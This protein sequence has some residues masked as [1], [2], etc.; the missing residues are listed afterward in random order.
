MELEGFQGCPYGPDSEWNITWANTAPGMN[1]TQPCPGGVNTVG[2]IV[3]VTLRCKCFIVFTSTSMCFT[4]CTEKEE[5]TS[6]QFS[7]RQFQQFEPTT[8]LYTEKRIF[9]VWIYSSDH[10]GSIPGVVVST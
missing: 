8:S 9:V 4:F 7:S 5:K 1:D 2:K 6:Q 3:M 10:E